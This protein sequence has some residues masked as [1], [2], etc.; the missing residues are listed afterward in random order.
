MNLWTSLNHIPHLHLNS[1]L[2]CTHPGYTLKE[3]SCVGG[4]VGSSSRY[5]TGQRY[6]PANAF[7]HKDETFYQSGRNENGT[8]NLVYP[9]PHLLWYEFPTAF[10]PSRI[11]FR[12][13]LKPGCGDNGFWCGATKWQFIASNDPV[14]NEKSAWTVLCEDLSGKPFERGTQSKYCDADD[15]VHEKFRCIGIS[16]LDSS[17]GGYTTV[18]VSGLRIW[19][20]VL[21]M[22]WLTISLTSY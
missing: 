3:I 15:S 7:Q 19:E 9:F 12:P 2:H 21:V 4:K 10:V 8:G 20:R 5:D 11:S 18:A 17:Y 14:C 16:V 6:Q 22:N 13:G 1:K